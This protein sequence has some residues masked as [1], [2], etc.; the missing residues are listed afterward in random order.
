MQSRLLQTEYFNPTVPLLTT[1]SE[2]FRIIRNSGVESFN[3]NASPEI[4]I[5]SDQPSSSD[6]MSKTSIQS[7]SRSS[8]NLPRAL[9]VEKEPSLRQD[10][11]ILGRLFMLERRLER[12]TG[13]LSP[14]SRTTE[15]G[16]RNET[17]NLQF[18]IE[19]SNSANA[20]GSYQPTTRSSASLNHSQVCQN[21]ANLYDQEFMDS[22]HQISDGCGTRLLDKTSIGGFVNQFVDLPSSPDFG[23]YEGGIDRSDMGNVSRSW[24]NCAKCDYKLAESEISITSKP[25]SLLFTL[26]RM[27]FGVNNFGATSGNTTLALNNR[28]PLRLKTRICRVRDLHRHLRLTISW[29]CCSYDVSSN[30][31]MF[32]SLLAA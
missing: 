21:T 14:V 4:D 5:S 17:Q 11:Q 13:L 30:Y 25:T 9:Q 8:E 29:N 6:S 3:V 22:Y 24:P 2:S 12:L 26:S 23:L 20:G 28:A 27:P 7:L 15:S 19:T 31:G 10:G 1:R 32:N 16:T 18:D